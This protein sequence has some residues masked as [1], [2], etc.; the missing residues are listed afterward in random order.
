M[1]SDITLGQFFPGYSPIHRL[2][3]R[4][5]IILA[6]L[7]IIAVFV[8]VNP[9]S[10]LLLTVLTLVLIAIS[11][12]SFKVI[13]KS[14]KPIVFILLFTALINIFMTK[15]EGT[16]LLSFWI[17]NIYEEGIA[18]AVMMA[19]R[20]IILIVGTS[21]LLTYTTSPISLTDGL[22]SLL[23]PL[24][25]INVPVHTF[26]MMM[27]IALRFIPTLVEETE[28]IMNA[29]KSRGADF[30]SGSLVQRAKALIPL[31]VPLFVSSFKRA[32][33]LATAMECRC[34]RGDKNRTKLVKLEYH[35]LDFSFMAIFALMLAGI[36]CLAILPYK[37]ESFG[38]I[39]NLL[40]YKV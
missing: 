34:Y 5:K 14:I 2:D 3:P 12:I 13:L 31:L 20:V 24:K 22:E 17:I 8:A 10:F 40:F 28:K 37:F 38:I 29:Q 19:L 1:I 30:T 23:S 25:K 35:G 15:G 33:E 4:T 11:R 9:V 16:P 26:A 27:S 18:R 32:E 6:T 36:I 7:F 39:Y 21:I